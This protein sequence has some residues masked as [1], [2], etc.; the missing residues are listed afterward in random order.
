M[1]IPDS[2]P[3]SNPNTTPRSTWR[4]NAVI[5][6]RSRLCSTV[7]L[8][9]TAATRKSARPHSIAP[10]WPDAWTPCD[11]CWPVELRPMCVTAN[12]PGR[13]LSWRPR[14]PDPIAATMQTMWRLAV[15][16]LMQ[17]PQRNGTRTMNPPTPC[18]KSWMPGP[19]CDRSG[20]HE[21]T[22]AGP[23]AGIPK[24]RTCHRVAVCRN[25]AAGLVLGLGALV[26]WDGALEGRRSPSC[27]HRDS[28]SGRQLVDTQG[29]QLGA[30][31]AGHLDGV[32]HCA[33]CVKPLDG[34][35]PRGNFRDRH[36]RIVQS[37]RIVQSHC[38][39]LFPEPS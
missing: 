9:R 13:H 38:V 36:C 8:T 2:P 27:R 37:R 4:R 34:C 14:A 31:A 23:T 24:E 35:D 10:R 6:V 30:L 22:T 25:W 32:A 39:A 1:R 18:W 19:A 20:N 12:S 5:R 17:D 33:Q 26:R 3:G 11:C 7:V 29:P 16:C 15:C 21:R 28:R